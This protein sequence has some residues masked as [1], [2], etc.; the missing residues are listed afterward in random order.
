M[1]NTGRIVI[2]TEEDRGE[3]EMINQA[4]DRVGRFVLF[5]EQK[6]N[7]DVVFAIEQAVFSEHCSPPT[8]NRN[9]PA[10]KFI[11]KSRLSTKRRLISK[12]YFTK[13]ALAFHKVTLLK[14]LWQRV[15]LNEA[16]TLNLEKHSD[17]L[18]D[19]YR[20]INFDQ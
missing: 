3:C 11:P 9:R 16:A 8:T 6:F 15:R 12:N 18:T 2:E 14:L 20:N 4:G 1:L 19:S 7:E 17:S 13:F 10:T 5:E